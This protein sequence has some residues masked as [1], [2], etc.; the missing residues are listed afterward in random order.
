[1]DILAVYSLFSAVL[2]QTVSIEAVVWDR[3]GDS[4]H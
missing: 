4:G 3:E 1:M 2:V